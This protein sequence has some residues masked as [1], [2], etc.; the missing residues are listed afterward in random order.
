MGTSAEWLLSVAIAFLCFVYWHQ[1][2]LHCE[3]R[4]E[5]LGI[6]TV[7][8]HVIEALDSVTAALKQL[9]DDEEESERW[10]REK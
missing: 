3:L 5:K 7:L 10:K 2:R 1:W 4:D 6:L 9:D 8:N